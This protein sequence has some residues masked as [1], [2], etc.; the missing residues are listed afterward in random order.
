MLKAFPY[1][2]TSSLIPNFIFFLYG[3]IELEY[4]GMSQTME[5]E[6]LESDTCLRSF[7]RGIDDFI[8]FIHIEERDCNER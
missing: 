8:N 2:Q 1:I 7:N 5:L 4:Y 3:L 6:E